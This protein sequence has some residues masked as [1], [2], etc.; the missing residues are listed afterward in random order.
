M[1]KSPH[2]GPGDQGT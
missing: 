1:V 2:A